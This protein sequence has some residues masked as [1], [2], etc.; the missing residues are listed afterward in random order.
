MDRDGELE[1][2]RH[3]ATIIVT[4]ASRKLFLWAGERLFRA[5]SKALRRHGFRTSLRLQSERLVTDIETV[6]L[7]V[8]GELRVAGWQIANACDLGACTEIDHN[9]MRIRR[10]IVRRVPRRRGLAIECIT[11]ARDDKNGETILVPSP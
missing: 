5:F 4:I 1:V 9:R 2:G 8:A 3:I 10:A 11:G 6:V 7:D